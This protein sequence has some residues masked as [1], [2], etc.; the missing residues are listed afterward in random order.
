MRVFDTR[1][2]GWGIT[3]GWSVHVKRKKEKRLSPED[4]ETAALIEQ[5]AG[6]EP[7]S[8]AWEAGI[9]PMNYTCKSTCV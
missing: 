6:I 1:I 3:A 4:P 2:E 5:V 7:V 9:L 8:P